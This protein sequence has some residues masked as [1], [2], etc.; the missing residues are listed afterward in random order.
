MQSEEEWFNTWKESI[1]NGVLGRKVGWITLEDWKD[2]H[3]CNLRHPQPCKDWGTTSDD[4]SLAVKGM[5]LK[6]AKQS[7]PETYLRGMYGAVRDR[8]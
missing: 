6:G 5:N 7:A 1:R 8:H 4:W 3:M 2:V